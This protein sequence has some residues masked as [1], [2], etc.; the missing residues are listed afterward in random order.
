MS[1]ASYWGCEK[2]PSKNFAQPGKYLK[3]ELTSSISQLQKH[4]PRRAASLYFD[5]GGGKKDF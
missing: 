2:E 5:F 4:A 3:S 1:C